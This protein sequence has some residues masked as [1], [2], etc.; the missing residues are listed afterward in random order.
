MRLE[1]DVMSAPTEETW[2]RIADEFWELWNFPNFAGA[3]DGRHVRGQAPQTAVRSFLKKNI[4]RFL[5]FRSH[6]LMRKINCYCG[7]RIIR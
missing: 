3:L 1:S 2:E 6:Y 5:L 4:I 7:Y